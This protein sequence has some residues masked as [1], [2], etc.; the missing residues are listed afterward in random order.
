[1][2]AQKAAAGVLAFCMAYSPS[3]VLSSRAAAA[4]E[5]LTAIAVDTAVAD[6]NG[7]FTATVYLN[8]LPETGLCAAEF[9]LAYDAAALSITD[10]KL[11]YDTG[12]QNAE[13]FAKLE[14][15]VFSYEDRG[16]LLWIRWGTGLMNADYWLKEEQAF[17]TVSGTLAEKMPAAVCCIG[18]VQKKVPADHQEERNA[19]AAGRK[20][21]KA[22]QPSRTMQR[23]HVGQLQPVDFMHTV[24]EYDGYD[25]ESPCQIDPADPFFS[26]PAGGSGNCILFHGHL[27][28]LYCNILKS[29]HRHG[30]EQV[31]PVDML[32]PYGKGRRS[33]S[34]A[35]AGDDTLKTGTLKQVYGKNGT[36]TGKGYL[37]TVI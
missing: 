32:W 6:G 26:G 27:L 30:T 19:Q 35:A 15:P 34:Q 24:T 10:V 16:G 23:R 14:Q 2:K 37:L 36:D 3:A 22:E 33:C 28:F 11:L 20:S 5:A 7:A 17:F 13:D 4:E 12:A 21:G 9:A 29:N 8:Q 1:M 31:L 18:P 25:S